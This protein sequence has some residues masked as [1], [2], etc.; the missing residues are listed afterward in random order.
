MRCTS[1]NGKYSTASSMIINFLIR[2]FGKANSARD[3]CPAPEYRQL[4]MKTQMRQSRE[5]GG[6]TG[7]GVNDDLVF[8]TLRD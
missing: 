7:I 6:H 1:R 4:K 5:S 8:R 2:S 3:N